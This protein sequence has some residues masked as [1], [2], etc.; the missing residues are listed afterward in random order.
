MT[1]PIAWGLLIGASL[2]AAPALAQEAPSCDVVRLGEVGWSDI[3]AT[4]ATATVVLNALGY[5]TTNTL[6]AV[7]IVFAGLKSNSLDVFLGNW[8]PTMESMIRPHLDDGSI[9]TV[10]ANLE[11]A[12][13]TLAVPA[14]TAEAGLKTFADITGFKDQLGG[15]I[16]GIEAG[17]DGNLI[18][19][20]MIGE[21]AFDLGSFT[22]VE[23]SEAGM[24]GEVE[25]AVRR[26]EPIVFLGWA[27]HPMNT[28][29]DIAYLYG[30]DDWFGPNFGGATVYTVVRAGY[31]EECPNVGLLLENL[32]FSLDMENE[33]MDAI[34]NDGQDPVEAA[35]AWL[36]AHPAALGPWLDGVT[37]KDGQE[38]L[39][40]VQ[41]SLEG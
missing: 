29:F 41:A 18:I 4:T 35:R 26:E 3:A 25:R 12:K 11:G 32:V 6:S 38:G 36:A 1:R 2:T 9:D 34:L 24:L 37:T 20:N 17:N 8:M 16:Y 39:P 7:P 33:I 22:L 19:E 10:R 30:G 28:N 13:Y 40:A 15:R 14:Y 23:S 31:A 27:P 5:E 21:N